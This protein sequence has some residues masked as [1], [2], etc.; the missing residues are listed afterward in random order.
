M[1]KGGFCIKYALAENVYS[2]NK[3]RKRMFFASLC[4]L[5]TGK[6]ICFLNTGRTYQS[7]QIPDR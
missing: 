6:F 5:M 2:F 7:V 3:D 1:R 4:Y